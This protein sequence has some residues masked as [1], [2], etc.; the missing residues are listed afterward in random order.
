MNDETECD[1]FL[2]Q[3]VTKA[4]DTCRF[5]KVKC[6]GTLPC[7]NCAG[8]HPT[9]EAIGCTYNYEMKRRLNTTVRT[10]N[11]QIYTYLDEK[12]KRLE[13]TLMNLDYEKLNRLLLSSNVGIK[14]KIGSS[15]SKHINQD[16]IKPNAGP[17]KRKESAKIVRMGINLPHIR[18]DN[19]TEDESQSQNI[20]QEELEGGKVFLC[21]AGQIDQ[22][23]VS[24]KLF[25]YL[26]PN[27]LKN[28]ISKMSETLT[29]EQATL[30][31][32]LVTAEK[33][34]KLNILLQKDNEVYFKTVFNDDSS[35]KTVAQD[36]KKIPSYIL[37]Y[38]I[39]NLEFSNKYFFLFYQENVYNLVKKFES[40]N[41]ETD[42]GEAVNFKGKLSIAEMSFVVT[43]LLNNCNFYKEQAKDSN[44]YNELILWENIWLQNA[45]FFYKSFTSMPKIEEKIQDNVYNILA[46]LQFAFYL[47]N[48]PSPRIST[49]IITS[50]ISYI[51][52]LHYDDNDYLNKIFSDASNKNS[53]N[54]SDLTAMKLQMRSLYLTCYLYDKNLSLRCRTP[55]ILNNKDQ[56]YSI[57]NQQIKYLVVLNGFGEFL[58]DEQLKNNNADVNILDKDKPIFQHMIKTLTGSHIIIQQLRLK[59]A[60]LHSLAYKYLI[61]AA[62][63]NDPIS[64]VAKKKI[65]VLESLQRFRF[66]AK[67]L[68]GLG[69]KKKTL[70]VIN[71]LEDTLKNEDE[72][73]RK[74]VEWQYVVVSLEYHTL[75]LL[76]HLSDLEIIQNI[77]TP[78]N[79]EKATKYCQ[80]PN[81]ATAVVDC[82]EAAM[83]T[84]EFSDWNKFESGSILYCFFMSISAAFNVA[85]F[86]KDFL[87]NNVD[88]IFKVIK[89]I[90][91]STSKQ[92]FIDPLKWSALSVLGMSYIKILFSLYSDLLE[93]E[94]GLNFDNIFKTDYF[95]AIS[96]LT[97]LSKQIIKDLD[98][99]SNNLKSNPEAF[100]RQ[101]SLFSGESTSGF[102]NNAVWANTFSKKN[103]YNQ[104][105]CN[106]ID[107]QSASLFSPLEKDNDMLYEDPTQSSSKISD[108]LSFNTESF[109]NEEL[110]QLL[111][112]EIFTSKD[113]GAKGN[114]AKDNA[115]SPVNNSYSQLEQSSKEESQQQP[116]TSAGG[117]FTSYKYGIDEFL[118]DELFKQG[119]FK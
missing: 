97:R 10:S 3:R 84:L 62:N 29:S 16:A 113:R 115:N 98:K 101:N 14:T 52:T 114:T 99:S 25:F 119:A 83:F 39:D 9:D 95:K 28:L 69:I 26:S 79:L 87:K 74:S 67:Y 12:M 56:A 90:T 103:I 68:F 6:S 58:T 70:D 108:G 42:D 27:N 102:K 4:C 11:K 47:E 80:C 93:K 23:K 63:E 36:I 96:T 44:F 22:N 64:F 76:I 51:Q 75:V 5:K 1:M 94:F 117:I 54:D 66:Q 2:N 53:G 61:A 55:A 19:S 30:D 78:E 50:C 41:N 109:L 18:T 116:F 118:E 57:M 38:I 71:F 13:S 111:D 35:S 46:L 72:T 86:S 91:N 49:S 45:I 82:L 100:S 34:E 20:A 73:S 88:L 105:D 31:N 40:I 32:I 89:I 81:L 77:N 24:A 92:C 43:I 21:D 85:L 104:L 15:F 107:K 106:D 7:V 33:M 48:S 37:A 17:K 65:L 110:F 60:Y 8:K 59:V 112:G